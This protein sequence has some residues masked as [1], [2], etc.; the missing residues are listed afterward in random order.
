MH[1]AFDARTAE[2]IRR[3]MNGEEVPFKELGAPVPQMPK[4]AT[5]KTVYRKRSYH[6]RK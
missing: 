3:R 6:L 1:D 4:A 5:N 2:W